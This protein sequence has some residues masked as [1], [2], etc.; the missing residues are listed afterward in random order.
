MQ[1]GFLGLVELVGIVIVAHQE[2]ESIDTEDLRLILKAHQKEFAHLCI[3]GLHGTLDFGHLEQRCTKVRRDLELSARG[4]IHILH[5][6]F[7]VLGVKVSWS[8]CGGEIPLG[9]CHGM[10]GNADAGE[11]GGG[12]AESDAS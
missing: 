6:Q 9:L 5:E 12:G 11:Q 3:A 8:V 1:R 7:V 4:G 10:T 2:R